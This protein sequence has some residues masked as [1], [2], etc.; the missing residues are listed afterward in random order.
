MNT[1]SGIPNGARSRGSL[2][3]N[4]TLVLFALALPTAAGCGKEEQ[5]ATPEPPTV[6][7][8]TVEQRDVPISEEWVGALDGLVNATI[9]AQVQG[10]LLKQNYR[11]G[12]P[13]RKGQVLFE[14]D[15]RVYQAALSQAKAAHGQAKGAAS[16]A[17]AA[18]EQAKA[19]VSL[20]DARWTTTKSNLARIKPL[21]EQ[22]ALSKKDLDDATGAEL[23]TRAAVEAA[24]A[25]VGAA[26]ANVTAAD[27]AVAGAQAAVDRAA[28]NLGFTRIDSPIEGVAGIA[29]A[30]IGNLVGPGSTEELTM[31]STIDPI[32]CYFAV[33]EQEYL[34]I[35]GGPPD[36]GLG[37][38]PLDL[39]LADGS[40]YAEKGRFSF[41]DRQVDPATGTIRVATLFPNP[42]KVLRPGQFGR[43]RAEM[44]I[45]R[46]ARLVPQR[47]VTALQGKFL[48]AVV[49]TDGK[50]AIRNIKA[51]ER[52]G[53]LWVIDEGL[54]P[55]EQVV[56]EGIQK[57]REGTVV[58]TTPFAPS[59]T[60]PAAAPG[61]K[62]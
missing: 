28:L 62:P 27:A 18:L 55:G 4:L 48:A 7:V 56:A 3:G 16:Q 26:E 37:E 43:V 51:G 5:K 36:R 29:K 46:G 12:D 23:S 34:R 2:K 19:E 9:R 42:T 10:I 54:E 50:V 52:I 61:A 53:Q 6:E 21:V 60:Q 31:V 44:R 33:S 15:P 39:I 22:N 13:V 40:T 24:K 47:A 45:K 11:E 38:I 57:V 8:V 20:Q 35:A 49:G 25:A 59:G 17:R 41:A 32:K 58:H 1:T 14:I 30:Q